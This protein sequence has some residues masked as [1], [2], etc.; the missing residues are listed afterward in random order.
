MSTLLLD[1]ALKLAAR[2]LQVF[3]CRPSGKIPVTPNG[4][5]DATTNAAQITAWWKQDDFN[6]GV[7][8]GAAS[9]IMVIDVDDEDAE[10]ELAKLEGKFGALPA[11]VEVITARGRH[12]YF[13]YPKH[14][15]RNSAG[16]IAPGIDVRGEGGFVIVPPS[17]HPSGKRYERSVD[18][19][20][21]VAAPPEWLLDVITAPKPMVTTETG[22]TKP[23]AVWEDVGADKGCRNDTM[24]RFVGML[25]AKGIDLIT[26]F[27]I[28]QAV[29]QFSYR[30]PMSQ[31]EVSGI[32]ESIATAE[33]RKRI[34]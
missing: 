16:K 11:T 9:N 10:A 4:C 21:T 1:T 24:A 19:A 30:P 8:T 31:G 17:R 33:L 18:S 14:G 32:V 22:V 34:A 13:R 3:P 5:K 7:A 2:G 28:A 26:T 23:P 6:I 12:I 27:Q 15:V 29:N 20:S 25:L